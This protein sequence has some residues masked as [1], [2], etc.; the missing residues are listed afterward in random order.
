MAGRTFVSDSSIVIAE[1]TL[2][3]VWFAIALTAVVLLIVGLGIVGTLI[4]QHLHEMEA[5][6]SGL[7]AALMLARSSSKSKSKFLSTMS[8]ELR[9]PL[10]III[11]NAEHL[12]TEAGGEQHPECVDKIVGNAGRLL[13]LVNSILD[14]AQF[15]AGQ[16]RLEE[17]FLDLARCIDAS[18]NLVR[19]EAD[20]AGVQLTVKI[21]PGLPKL[22]G[23]F[24]RICQILTN[25][26]SNG[27]HFTPP[28]GEVRVWAF[29]R[30]GGVG[31]SVSDTGVGMAV[32]QI[33]KALERFGQ[34][35]APLERKH[36]G[37]GLG[38]PLAQHL[39]EL[40]GGKLRIASA[41]GVGTTVTVTFPRR[42][43]VR[44]RAQNWAS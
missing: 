3:L 38:L 44:E 16:L 22:C 1:D 15:D 30:D 32:N 26:V 2:A 27:I 31:I 34:L 40:H 41:P 23:D 21:E 10:N 43:I 13:R 35:D 36:E 39:M 33:P 29:R 4:D 11:G 5:R 17:E 18:I 7:E 28:H 24:K 19:E 8:H 14:I 20:K 6:K 12:M 9:S 25:L 37:A 42:R